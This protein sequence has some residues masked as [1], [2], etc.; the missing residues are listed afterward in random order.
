MNA[1]QGFTVCAAVVFCC[2][3]EMAQAE[4]T[5][6]SDVNAACNNNVTVST[7][8][9]SISA[10]ACDLSIQGGNQSSNITG[11]Q[12]GG[13]YFVHA[14]CSNCCLQATT[15]PEKILNLTVTEVTT[16][17]VTLSWTKPKGL[18]SFYAVHWTDG[19]NSMTHHVTDTDT[20]I[21]KLTAGVEYTITVTA[22]AG[23]DQTAGKNV[24]VTKYTRP[25]KPVHV[26]VNQR[27]TDSLNISWTL[28][29]GR[30]DH[31]EVQLEGEI[32]K[33]NRSWFRFTNLSPGRLFEVNVTAVAGDFRN[34]SKSTKFA[35]Y[36]LPPE[37]IQITGRT[38]DSL[39]L[40][41]SIYPKMEDAPNISYNI[42][43]R[44]D[45]PGQMASTVNNATL[46][47]LVPGSLY[48]ITVETVGPE[49]LLSSEA[50]TSA[51]TNPNPVLSLK[52]SPESNT[53]VKVE[54]SQTQDY[55]LNYSYSIV[56]YNATGNVVSNQTIPGN[57]VS[58]T[59]LD[60]GTEYTI[61]VTTQVTPECQSTEEEVSSY[62]R[63]A[64]P[65]HVTVNQ[66]MTD[67]LNISWTLP[68][69]RVDH[70]E[71]QLEGE[72][73]KTNRS[74]FRF[75]N[76]SPGRLFEVNVTAVAGDFRNTSKSTK[77]ATYPLPP[78]SIQ[79]T[80]RTNDSLHLS[81]SIYP[82]MEDAPNIS[83]NITYRGD[84][85]GQMASTVNN[86][87]LSDLVPG[88]LYD[89]TVETVGPE[90]L[91]SSEAKTSA[92]TNP[93]PVLSLKASPESNTSVKVEWSQPQDYKLN[94]SYSIVTYNATGNVVSNQTIPGNIVSVTGLDPGTEYTIAVTT[95]V[96]PECQS[97]EEEVSSYTKPN[98]VSNLL[99]QFVNTTAITLSWDN[100]TVYD[101][102]PTYLVQ[103]FQGLDK[104]Y[105]V[106]TNQL[107]HTIPGLTPGET[108]TFT[109]IV[110]VAN[111][112]SSEETVTNTMRP[113][114]VTITEISGSTNILTVSWSA[115]QGRVDNYTVFLYNQTDQVQDETV[116]NDSLSTSFTGL[117]PG[118]EYCAEVVT[119]RG[120]LEN[121]YSKSCN[122]T[123]PNPP[124]NIN[125][126]QTERSILFT[127]G[128]PE[129]MQPDTYGF[130]VTI[131]N[132]TN[133]INNPYFK[134]E[135]CQPGSPYTISV[136]T[137]G[138]YNYTS[139]EVV[140]EAFTRPE[141]VTI[142]EI[143]GSTN[144][145][146]VSWSAAQGRVDNYTVILYLKNDQVQNET[147]P[148]D[149]LNTSFTGLKPG[150]EYCAEVVTRSGPLANTSPQ[151]CNATFPNPPGSI[152]VTIQT[153]QSLTFAWGAPEDMQSDQ[154]DFDVTFYNGTTVTQKN[155]T[156][157]LKDLESGSPY[158]ISVVTVGANNLVSQE[159]VA[160][161]YTRPYPVTELQQTE[162]TPDSVT[163]RWN[164]TEH[165]P[166]YTYLVEVSNI[167]GP[168]LPLMNT[169]TLT[170]TVKG[171]M[172]GTNYSFSV[173]A[174]TADGTAAAPNTV[175]YFTRPFPV[176]N[177]Q[178]VPSERSVTLNWS[179][180]REYKDSYR[181]IVELL[182]FNGSI[183]KNPMSTITDLDSGTPYNFTV[184]TETS[185]GTQ[186]APK[187][188]SACTDA[189][190]VEFHEC[191]APD[192]P[193]ANLTWNWIHTEGLFSNFSV[194]FGETII[195]KN[196][197][198]YCTF[199][200][201]DLDHYRKY[202]VTVTTQS[203]GNPSSSISKTCRTGIT[204][205]P[206][207]KNYISMLE[208]D[209]ITFNAFTIIIEPSL[210]NNTN[211]PIKHVGVLVTK[212]ANDPVVSDSNVAEY[213]ENDYHQWKAGES[214][215]YLA[216]GIDIDPSGNGERSSTKEPLRI[217]V[218]NG[219]PWRG[220]LNGNLE[221]TE[222]YK[223]AIVLF[224]DL[225]I[226]SEVIDASG[227][228]FT[229]TGF[230][231]IQP[232]PQNP[233]VIGMAVGV[234]MGIFCVLLIVL[235]GFII[236]WRRLA[237]KESSDV[238]IQSLRS[239]PV[240]VE[241]F[242]V[243]Y[244]KQKADSNCGFAEEYEDLKVT[245]TGQSK[246]HALNPENKPKNRY[247]NVVPYDA[248]RVKLSIIHGNPLD[249]YINAN[250][251]PGYIS[252]KEFIA[253]QGPLR[254]TVNDFWRM[255]WEKNVHTIVMLTR[256]NEQGRV[257]CEQYWAPGTSSYGN[258]TVTTTSEIPLDDWTIRDFDVKN[259]KTAETR[260]VRHF[261]FT[262]WPDHG[263]PETTELL[264][265][266][267]HLVRE[268]M[269]Q[270]KHSPT[271]VHCSAGVGR[272][273]TFIAIDRLIF[274]IERENVVDVYGI[275]YD[276]RLHRV[277]MVQTEDQYVFL[278]QCALDI[279]RSRTGNNV[280][281]IYQNMAALSIYEHIELQKK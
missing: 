138:V 201:A 237:S 151:S 5:G 272:T 115:A 134:L 47:D 77:F 176:Q 125:V 133:D 249:D 83:Y 252:R 192:G 10:Q 180:P 56:T 196:C 241:D 46:S 57:I 279:I 267:R 3:L 173:T 281:L 230:V 178:A 117:K 30:V 150:V 210:L 177:L 90:D 71:V 198:D 40:S 23:D 208:V 61:A 141:A 246:I 114:A 32:N 227:S 270:Y 37:S 118:V 65:V 135:G 11:L 49:D 25:A 175:H 188:I 259:V 181:F 247:S 186:G 170:Y 48:D 199:K 100:P 16:S 277:L 266:F 69:G 233:V 207:S 212:A 97:T 194:Q 43:Y 258:I 147:V 113:E 122:A 38:N 231:S 129:D 7:T 88:S 163:L 244:K 17:D 213:L 145:L 168:P 4:C 260:P 87:T 78:E 131:S 184:T 193:Y 278:N 224:T 73:N 232:L 162:I 243:Y 256:C 206:V 123:F 140:K 21:S 127:W 124:G 268:N 234:T 152:N 74:W 111:V 253:A 195:T 51:C 161:A 136:A 215:V 179:K 45:V 225:Q 214:D 102:P 55:K 276:M 250:Y 101:P 220:Y 121:N 248:S 190:P 13:V 275:V 106:S 31:Y 204:A 264:I 273:G 62:T 1:L 84:V 154:Y 263:V 108:Y 157:T 149:S 81:W 155:T 174:Q 116:A 223:Y 187:I 22:V 236:Y 15:K 191:N 203:C 153:V 66:R 238:Q 52:A 156:V 33:T 137:V 229:C 96:T 26:T 219:E 50:K 197:D 130:K 34:T 189:S 218:G 239:V 228:L 98:A 269:D 53:S 159:V 265:S 164:Q 172:S 44:G 107:S 183:E 27:M 167:S 9:T 63:P 257:K 103:A 80:G 182:G 262:A 158:N 211:G 205:P 29:E 86:A 144:D 119:R 110:E 255:I 245:G 35:T 242:E 72:I 139:K 132:K 148:D 59:G 274:Q 92:C 54:W 104:V 222:K 105:N 202:T 235:V 142:T 12:P 126:N 39:H 41:W 216:T 18:S 254:A 14:H 280:D 200:K 226:W 128:L 8:T 169:S 209:D 6:Q 89:I 165:K 68:E 146:T 75:T 185:D 160:V 79:I 271:V 143:T 36:P 171:L 94:Y 2:L 251:I 76:L 217:R 82:K 93:N 28:P 261:H 85:P 166:D 20:V 42:T 58:V 91:L 67:S 112:R 240:R 99:V 60:P 64:K 120:P 221:P 109:V 24:T 95:Q 19:N 70:Y